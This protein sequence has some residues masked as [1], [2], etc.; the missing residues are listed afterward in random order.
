VPKSLRASA[1][2]LFTLSFGP[3]AECI[4]LVLVQVRPRKAVGI[5]FRRATIL[6]KRPIS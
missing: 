6:S 2:N 4:Q 1:I 5:S 3:L